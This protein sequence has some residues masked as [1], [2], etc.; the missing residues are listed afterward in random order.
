[1][2]FIFG[3]DIKSCLNILRKGVMCTRSLDQILIDKYISFFFVQP[4]IR[5]TPV[6]VTQNLMTNCNKV[7]IN[8]V[9]C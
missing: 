8:L 5:H 2:F 6:V 4:T 9:C 3:K 7:V 1:M